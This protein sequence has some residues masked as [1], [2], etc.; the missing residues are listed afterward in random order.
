MFTHLRFFHPSIG[1]KISPSDA[2]GWV[3]TKLP[4]ASP[5]IFNR[6]PRDPK[7]NLT[8]P[9]PFSITPARETGVEITGVGTA[10]ASALISWSLGFQSEFRAAYPDGE[11][12]MQTGILDISIQPYLRPAVVHD[13]VLQ[14]S[15]VARSMIFRDWQRDQDLGRITKLAEEEFHRR[16]DERTDL[17][18]VELPEDFIAGD[19]QAIPCKRP[20]YAGKQPLF[21]VELRFRT[22]AHFHGPWNLGHLA[23]RG[24]GRVI[25]V[26]PSRIATA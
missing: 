7:K 2:R 6:D 12:S 22:N 17:V 19:F 1:P 20:V 3:S 23:N 8:T 16:L 14:N 13:F 5:E 26:N 9:S 11:F 24:A 10:A 21:A 4:S 18:G 25:N 15:G